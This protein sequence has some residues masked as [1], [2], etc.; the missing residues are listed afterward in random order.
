[1]R[2]LRSAGRID[3]DERMNELPACR[4]RGRCTA[5]VIGTFIGTENCSLRK[6]ICFWAHCNR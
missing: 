5:G 2:V 4:G 1:V 3:K 6:A